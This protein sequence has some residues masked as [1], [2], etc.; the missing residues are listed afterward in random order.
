[1]SK[2]RA[3]WGPEPA[4]AAA[5][6]ADGPA[7]SMAKSRSVKS[8]D[9]QR[10]APWVGHGG[11]LSPRGLALSNGVVIA[12]SPQVRCHRSMSVGFMAMVHV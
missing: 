2:H 10:D 6:G 7:A 11:G 9:V 8:M 12:V 3:I 5:A 4:A 1:M